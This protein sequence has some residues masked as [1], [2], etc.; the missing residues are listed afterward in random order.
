MPVF[1]T[2]RAVL[3]ALGVGATSGCLGLREPGAPLGPPDSDGDGVKD[4]EDD[5]PEN[6]NRYVKY[7]EKSRTVEIDRWEPVTIGFPTSGLADIDIEVVSGP[8]VNVLVYG[9]KNYKE[10]D[11]VGDRDPRPGILQEDITSWSDTIDSVTPRWFDQGAAVYVVI[12]NPP[13]NPGTPE[14]KVDIVRWEGPR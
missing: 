12:E 5:Y 4:S 7:G 2:R 8:A 9:A 11:G 10:Y 14:V 13:S 1:K 6:P 3:A